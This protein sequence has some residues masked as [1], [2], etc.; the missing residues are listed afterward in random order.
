M[1][2]C[3]VM[4]KEIINREGGILMTW[5]LYSYVYKERYVYSIDIGHFND[6]KSRY[7]GTVMDK[8]LVNR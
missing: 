4:H 1:E 5:K 3:T 6:L 8:K 7:N 2:N